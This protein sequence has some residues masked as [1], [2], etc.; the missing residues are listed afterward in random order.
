M[1]KH[2]SGGAKFAMTSTI[3]EDQPKVS[4]EQMKQCLEVLKAV[5]Q[6]RALLGSLEHDT[7]V[8]F[9]MAAGKI[10]R[11]H[12]LETIRL[13]KQIRKTKKRQD[14]QHDKALRS[15]S[16]IRRVREKEV[17]LAPKAESQSA[18]IRGRLKKAERC[19]VCKASFETLQF[20]PLY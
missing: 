16:Q 6:D 19:Y 2:C 12:K 9:L 13:G 5:E 7:R 11:P 3:M 15:R 4:P 10:S 17:Y 20:S 14:R 18:P 1:R 8:E